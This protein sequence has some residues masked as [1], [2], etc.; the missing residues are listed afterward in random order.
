M[1]RTEWLLE[2]LDTLTSLMADVED[3][4]E[5]LRDF[6]NDVAPRRKSQQIFRELELLR[7]D[8]QREINRI[9]QVTAELRSGTLQEEEA[10][11]LALMLFTSA[12]TLQQGLVSFAAAADGVLAPS[13]ASPAPTGPRPALKQ[14]TQITHWINT[15][16]DSLLKRIVATAWKVLSQ[17]LTPRGWSVRG[18]LGAPLL[19]LA[20]VEIEIAC[21]S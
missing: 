5:R 2:D 18:G 14:G 15:H 19:G 8:A 3:S 4:L 12:S 20:S 21:G 13:R 17:L 10:S 11:Q 7:S 9:L 1:L 6:V 16:L